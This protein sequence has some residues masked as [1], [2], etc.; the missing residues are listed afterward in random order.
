MS[1]YKRQ[2][3]FARS[4]GAKQ[5]SCSHYTAICNGRVNKR[6]ESRTHE[7]PLVAEHGKNR[8]DLETT[9]AAPAAHTR[10]FLPPAAATL[11]GKTQGFVLRLSPQNTSPMQ[12]PCSHYTAICNRRVNKRKGYWGHLRNL[13]LSHLRTPPNGVTYAP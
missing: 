7:Q 1:R 4:R 8:F 12:R 13:I 11:H 5:H 9:A 6:K 2:K 3:Y 10:Y